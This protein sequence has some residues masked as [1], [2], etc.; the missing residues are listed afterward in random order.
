VFGL[1]ADVEVPFLIQRAV[2]TG[3]SSWWVGVGTAVMHPG[4]PYSD[5]QS[6]IKYLL[7]FLLFFVVFWFCCYFLFNPDSVITLMNASSCS[8]GGSMRP[9]TVA[10]KTHTNPD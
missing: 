10:K 5:G 8:C 9:L 4:L 7:L 3:G 6:E 2:G 1:A